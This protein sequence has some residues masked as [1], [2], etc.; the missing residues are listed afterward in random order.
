[1]LKIGVTGKLYVNLSVYNGNF[2]LTLHYSHNSNHSH[3][4][5]SYPLFPYKNFP[6]ASTS[7]Y[8]MKWLPRPQ[9]MWVPDAQQARKK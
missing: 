7:N 8:T 4:T 3:D 2:F 5:K 1:M 9:E 6:M